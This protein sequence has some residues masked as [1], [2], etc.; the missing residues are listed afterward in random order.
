MIAILGGGI[1]AIAA[2]IE[3][4]KRGKD[5]ILIEKSARLGGK[6][7]SANVEGYQLEFG[8]NTVLINHPETK[9]F[10]E[11]LELYEERIEPDP[12]AIKRRFV[13]KDGKA[14]AIPYSF[15]SL[16][17]SKLIG[18]SSI[19][20]ILK[21]AF[22]ASKQGDQ[23]ESL[24][25]FSR[26]RF[27]KQV[28]EDLITPFVSGIYAGDPEKMSLNYTMPLLSQAETKFGSVVKGMPKLIKEKR[29]SQAT[30]DMP[31]QKMFSF[32]GGLQS[33]IDGATQKIIENL[34]LN[35][36]VIGIEA[37]GEAYLLKLATKSDEKEIQVDQ[38]I[39][40]LP[41]HQLDSLI[42]FD[43]SFS[44]SIKKINYVPAVVTHLAF[45][46]SQWKFKRQAFGLLSRKA[47]NVPWLGI[48]FN[49]EF[50]P[51]QQK[52][53]DIL[54]TVISGGY[55]Q[56]EMIK[57]SDAEILKKLNQSINQIG[58]AEGKAI[59]QHIYRWDLA[60]P[61]YEIGYSTI[62]KE[63]ERFSAQYPNFKVAG[64]YHNGV[65]VSD[66]I[67]NGTKLAAEI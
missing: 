29:A 49:S 34:K 27:G 4:K 28:Y 51:Q 32:E 56:P 47:E 44:S 52:K 60:I 54:I 39:S 35:T 5:F 64:N 53:N 22:K 50:F 41:A 38:I 61:Q 36:E 18:L 14:E 57:L 9:A 46:P 3:L 23:E 6:I 15:G 24:A 43:N 66:C 21:E 10:L 48:L 31:N 37:Q 55:R 42:S 11:Y 62:A 19:F 1:S 58:L 25:D 7:K 26:R 63:I 30:F 59:F 45:S 65:S 8:P 20:S 2:A 67:T 40:T 13:L 33:M 17:G 16:L 12:K